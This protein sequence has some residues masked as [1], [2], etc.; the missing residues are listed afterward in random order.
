MLSAE[1]RGVP[2]SASQMLVVRN[3]GP[4]IARDVQVAFEPP[5]EMPENPAGLVTP[6]LL[7]RYAAQ[8]PVMTP[9]MELDNAY[10]VAEEGPDRKYINREPLPDT[11]TVRI[12]YKSDDGEPYSDDFPLDVQLLRQRTLV[13]PSG[14]P[15]GQTKQ[16]L[17]YLG[18]VT[19]SLASLAETGALLTREERAQQVKEMMA[20]DGP[21][22]EDEGQQPPEASG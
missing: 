5:I 6:Y 2:F 17:K 8:I 3:Y 16:A 22:R 11:V 15:E 13:T 1:L 20:L 14:S 21:L 19:R 9:G 18:E 10:F 12:S 4:S 7:K